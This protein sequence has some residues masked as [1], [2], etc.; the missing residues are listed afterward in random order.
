M[1]EAVQFDLGPLSIAV[2]SSTRG[3]TELSVSAFDRPLGNLTTRLHP[4]LEELLGSPA[5]LAALF[6]IF[7]DHCAPLLR[8][9]AEHGPGSTEALCVRLAYPCDNPECN[10]VHELLCMRTATELL[11]HA[12]APAPGSGTPF[13]LIDNDG[14]P[15]AAPQYLGEADTERLLQHHIAPALVE[16]A[17]FFTPGCMET[18]PARWQPPT[19]DDQ[20]IVT[21]FGFFSGSPDPVFGI[22][23]Y[24]NPLLLSIWMERISAQVH[25]ASPQGQAAAQEAWFKLLAKLQVLPEGFLG[26]V[27]ATTTASTTVHTAHSPGRRLH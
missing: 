23:Q 15:L 24:I 25:S 19:A 17:S 22:F 12:V 8:S 1:S 21:Y 10:A 20:D 3:K 6:D 27:A 5:E 18:D 9:R 2:V 7:K 16:M 11:A 26:S 4:D 14:Q 13:T